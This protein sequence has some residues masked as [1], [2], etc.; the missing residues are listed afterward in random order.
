MSVPHRGDSVRARICALTQDAGQ[1]VACGRRRGRYITQVEPT[2]HRVE[3]LHDLMSPWVDV[4][5]FPDELPEHA[6]IRQ[7]VEDFAIQDG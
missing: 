7:E 3:C 6:D 5:Q 2:K 4:A 1:R